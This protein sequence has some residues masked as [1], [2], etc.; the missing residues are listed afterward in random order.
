M[1]DLEEDWGGAFAEIDEDW[2]IVERILPAGWE[3]AAKESGAMR[4]NRGFDGPAS[5]LRVLLIHLADGCS[6]R[7]TVTR[8]RQCC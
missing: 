2:H 3:A 1:D 8:A 6:L 7:E 5:L 4:R